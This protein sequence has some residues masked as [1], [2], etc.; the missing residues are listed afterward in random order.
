M[1][2]SPGVPRGRGAR[3][4]CIIA[5]VALLTTGFP[6]RGG[7][8]YRGPLQGF[9]RHKSDPKYLGE[10]P[11]HRHRSPHQG[12]RFGKCSLRTL[13]VKTGTWT[14]CTSEVAS[15]HIRCKHW[16]HGIASVGSWGTGCVFSRPSVGDGMARLHVWL[17]CGVVSSRLCYGIFYDGAA[18][19]VGRCHHCLGQGVWGGARMVET[20]AGGGALSRPYHRTPA[21]R[22]YTHAKLEPPCWLRL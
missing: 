14:S 12:D 9:G 15:R 4:G 21:P 18:R 22:L 5:G 6:I 2:S 13:S 19:R 11:F 20:F 8:A 10:R 17:R 3:V 1:R 16:L 7:L